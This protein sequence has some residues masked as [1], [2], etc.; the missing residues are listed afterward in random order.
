[1]GFN[2]LQEHKYI[3][4]S[5]SNLVDVITCIG[6]ITVNLDFIFTWRYFNGLPLIN[7]IT[8]KMHAVVNDFYRKNIGTHFNIFRNLTIQFL[9]WQS[10]YSNRSNI[11]S[12][13]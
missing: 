2:I 5:N 7:S 1:M 8:S 12:I 13:I 3:I 9:T 4:I 11:I 10:D 6:N